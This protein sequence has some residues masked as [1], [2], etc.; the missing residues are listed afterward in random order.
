MYDR[1]VPPL[2]HSLNAMSKILDK[3]EA[4]CTEKKI[5]PSVLLHARLYPDMLTF[6]RQ[7]QIAC[8]HARRGL[9]RLTGTEPTP[10]ADTESS[11]AELRARIARTVEILQ[12]VKP[13]DLAGAETRSITI[14]TGGRDLTL[15]GATYFSTYLL[16]N[17]Y[18]HLATAYGILRHNGVVIGKADFLGG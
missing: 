6:T 4:Y 14:K 2:V 5:D 11:F 15:P 8:D 12:A 10:I 18:F 17:F 1:T 13:E 16:P 3:A 9:S 7:I